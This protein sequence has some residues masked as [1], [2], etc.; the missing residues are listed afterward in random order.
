MFTPF[1]MHP[2]VPLTGQF[3]QGLNNDFEVLCLFRIILLPMT[4]QQLN[5]FCTRFK[6]GDAN[7]QFLSE[8]C[9]NPNDG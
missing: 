6:S 1:A 5:P 7:H 2:A 3:T 4:Q 9:L 8:V